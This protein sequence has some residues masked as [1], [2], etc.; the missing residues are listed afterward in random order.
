MKDTRIWLLLAG[1]LLF[2]PGGG[3]AAKSKAARLAGNL[4]RGTELE[5][6]SPSIEFTDFQPLGSAATAEGKVKTGFRFS[7]E[8]KN[9]VL[10]EV[11]I[12]EAGWESIRDLKEALDVVHARRTREDMKLILAAAEEF[13]ARTGTAPEASN[14][15]Q[16]IDQLSPHYLN[17]VIRLD[18]W[19]NGY[20]VTV[21]QG[22]LTLISAGPDGK[23]NTA[24]DIRVP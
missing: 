1:V 2:V 10:K 15:V 8:G 20:G 11:R 6:L 4:L 7:R 3:C 13:R 9:W 12:G 16:L 21:V 17:R 24:D 18:A 5:A 23:E 14:F 19:G 22:K